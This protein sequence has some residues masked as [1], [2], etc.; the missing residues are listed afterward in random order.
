M[1]LEPSTSAIST[2]IEAMSTAHQGFSPCLYECRY[3]LY[4][5]TIKRYGRSTSWMVTSF[6]ASLHECPT[7]HIKP[8]N[9]MVYP[10]P[11]S[12]SELGYF[13]SR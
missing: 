11:I 2:S 6:H 9:E 5:L 7:E 3:V 13:G 8:Q 12:F 10:Y 1:K 4:I